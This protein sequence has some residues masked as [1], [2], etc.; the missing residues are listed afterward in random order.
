MFQSNLSS[1]YQP[2]EC[3]SKCNWDFG[4]KQCRFHMQ[5]AVTRGANLLLAMDLISFGNLSQVEPLPAYFGCG[6]VTNGEEAYGILGLG[7]TGYTLLE[8]LIL[9]DE[10]FHSFSLCFGGM[11][12]DHG[13]MFLGEISPPTDMVF[14]RYNPYP[15]CVLT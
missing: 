2:V 5:Y 8:E 6:D 11:G 7:H 13:A 1:T 4:T 9:N 12:V 14:A 3:N 15:R 10:F